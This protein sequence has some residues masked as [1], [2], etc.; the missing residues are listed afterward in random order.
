M[1]LNP[2]T[3]TRVSAC[4]KYFIR[5]TALHNDLRE[6]MSRVFRSI[7]YSQEIDT[8]LLTSLA[9]RKMLRGIRNI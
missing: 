1:E 6:C 2:C 5:I 3:V 4:R 9:D 7:F 8:M